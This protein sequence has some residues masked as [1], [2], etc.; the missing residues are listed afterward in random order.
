[1]ATLRANVPSR[2]DA[3]TWR[4]AEPPA[5]RV[6]RA[7]AGCAL[8]ALAVAP[9][10][11]LLARPETGLAGAAT[12]DMASTYATLIVAGS[13]LTAIVALIAAR[14]VR[15]DTVEG[16]W[17][18]FTAWILQ[19][20]SRRFAA[21]LALIAF[22][23][24]TVVHF[25]VLRGQPNLIDGMGQ[26]LHA[27]YLAE[28]RLSGP[29]LAD[30]AFWHAQQTLFT[31]AGWLSQY[32]PLHVLLLAAGVKSG[33]LW[34]TGPLMLAAAAFFTALAAERLLPWHRATA[35]LGAALAAVSPFLLAHAGAFTSHTTAAAL[36]AAAVYCTAR[37]AA[38]DARWS[39]GVGAAL[40]ALLATRPLSAV[41]LGAVLVAA[42]LLWQPIRAGDA[43]VR[44][45]LPRV[46]AAAA[47]TLPFALLLAAYNAHFFGAPWRFGYT[48]A[49]GADG[50][51]GF[52]VDPWGN[53]YGLREAVGAASAELMS[54][55]LFLLE[56]P[57]PTVAIVG[58]FLALARRLEPGTWVLAGWAIAPVFAGLGY[59]HHGL[60]MGP[61]ML[62]ESAPAWC[63]LAAVAA[64]WW[65]RRA[66]ARGT[67]TFGY[68]P[69]PG[70]AVALAVACVL[71]VAVLG[72]L[73]LSTY[74][75][76]RPAAL[77]LAGAATGLPLVF[78]HGGWTARLGARLAA[79]GMRLDSVETALRQNT[80]CA[81][82]RY[83]DARERG[84]VL[85]ALDFARRAAPRD[86]ADPLARL[87]AVE[88][89]RGNRARVAHGEPFG[90]DCAREAQ[91]DRAGVLDVTPLLWQGD[92][93]GLRARG[94]M[95][96]RDLGPERNAALIAAQPAR[97]PYLLLADADGRLSLEPYDA[98][99]FRLW[100]RPAEVAR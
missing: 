97:T 53:A 49:L 36:A 30:G 16:A 1:M 81:V 82:H 71:G 78:V 72:P 41:T 19:P 8:A 13:A 88:L 28:G 84:A 77:A 17:L 39:L 48:A 55:N 10:Y 26:L 59:W 66:P 57:L 21:T 94:P 5:A 65:V 9:A 100:G 80:T 99:A 31:D 12:V 54:L 67:R 2:A 29:P 64:V 68:A 86:A 24:A 91:A 38:G 52:G 44:P 14:T 83:A 27:R 43:R 22:A 20:S 32:P 90:A 23:A 11:R 61:R 89:S 35:R 18:R 50:G 98:A 3:R 69:R 63:V 37:V 73:R 7:S 40:G 70:I 93:P 62:N 79:S 56:T 74:R 92:L 34:A 60:F 76:E 46:A 85:P 15:A 33:L 45:A 4:I 47:G 25:A 51:L 95:F 42:L 6:V 58:G 96:A 87:R 75:Q